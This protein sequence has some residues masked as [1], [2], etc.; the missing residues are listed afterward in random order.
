M[1]TAGQKIQVEKLTQEKGGKFDFDKVLMIADLSD[2]ASA[3][4]GGD[5]IEVGKP[6]LEGK[7]IS[8]ELMDQKRLPKVTT[9]KYHSKTRF[10]KK[11]GHKQ[12]V[13]VV[14]IVSI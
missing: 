14:K 5:K 3:K 11:T 12:P 6:Y 8:A 1:V 7:K 9:F 2:E 4:A 10:R 13:S